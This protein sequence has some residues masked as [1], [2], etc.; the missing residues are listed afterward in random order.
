MNGTRTV[1]V[2][3]WGNSFG[4]RL[5]KEFIDS[6]NITEKSQVEISLTDEG[7]LVTRAK[8]PYKHIHLAE[9]F[10]DYKGDYKGEAINWGEDVGGEICD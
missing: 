3:R 10:K 5:P 4:I 1:R 6:A 9:R 8:E 7:L 2:N